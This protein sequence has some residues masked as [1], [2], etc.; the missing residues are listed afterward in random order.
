M[1][2]TPPPPDTAP[3]SALARLLEVESR[4]EAMLE[5]ARADAGRIE[6]RARQQAEARAGRLAADL[7]AADAEL[8]A[9]LAV[10]S[11]ARIAREQAHLAGVRARY[12]AVDDARATALSAWLVDEVLRMAG[13]GPP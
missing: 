10:E 6:A 9:R 2:R 1:R 11:E 7:A 12:E 8:T 13:E 5:E 3:E 4:L